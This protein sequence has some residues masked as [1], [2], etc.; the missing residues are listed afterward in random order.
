MIRGMVIIEGSPRGMVKQ[1]RRLVKEGLINLVSNFWHQQV[2]PGHF[3][4][5]AKRKYKYAPRD[6]K[7]TRRKA[8]RKPMAGPLEFSGRSK[9]MLTRTIRV[10]GTAKKAT[11]AMQAPRYFWMTPKN[12]PDKPAEV[13]AVTKRE[14]L[15]MAKMLNSRVTKRLNTLKDRRIYK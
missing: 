5:E 3:K 9:R 7:Y 11:G 10:S 6:L 12:H 8:K 14:T 2:L 13:T 4:P 15:T 1:F